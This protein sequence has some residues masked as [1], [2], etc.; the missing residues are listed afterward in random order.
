MH[1]AGLTF[2]S[3]LVFAAVPICAGSKLLAF[4]SVAAVTFAGVVACAAGF[5]LLGPAVDVRAATGWGG[6]GADVGG[7]VE[8]TA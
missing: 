4:A 8:S 6:R 1:M 2:L 5:P 3:G 7:S